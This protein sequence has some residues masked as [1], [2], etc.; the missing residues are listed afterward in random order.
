MTIRIAVV[1]DHPLFREGVTRS[2]TETGAFE[3]VGEGSSADDAV[4]IAETEQPHILLLDISMPGGGLNAIPRVLDKAPGQKIV[5]LTVSEASEDL[6]AALE[7]GACGYVLK[8]VGSRALSEILTAVASGE[9]YVSPALSA[10]LLTS[11]ATAPAISAKPDPML[12]LTPREHEILKLVATGLSNKRVALQLALH[13]KTVKH[14]MTSIMAKLSVSNRT[15][16]ALVFRDVMDGR[17]AAI[18]PHARPGP[19]QE[20]RSAAGE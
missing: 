13:E 10:R 17:P 15:E 18:A 7:S 4:R 19:A 8:G 1:D 12:E 5:L 9:R 3:V 20:H 11:L 16:A 14:H 2:L 6:A